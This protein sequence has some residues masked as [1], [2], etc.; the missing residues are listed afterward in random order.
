MLLAD[1]I[2]SQVQPEFRSAG[3]RKAKGMTVIIVHSGAGRIDARI[4]GPINRGIN[5]RTSCRF[6]R[7]RT[8]GFTLLEA[9]VALIIFGIIMVAMSNAMA[10]ALRAR[11]LA[12]QRQE[13]SATARAIFA[14]LGRDLMSAYGSNYDPNSVFMTGSGS[15]S[16]GSV[17]GATGAP[18]LTFASMVQRVITSDSNVDPSSSISPAGGAPLSLGSSSNGSNDPP[19]NT[20][21]LIRY[22]LDKQTGSLTRIVQAIP[23]LQLIQ[24]ASPASQNVVAMHI[25]DLQIQFWDPNQQTWRS[26]WD[27]E[28]QNLPAPDT[29]AQTMNFPASTTTSSTSSGSSSSSSSSTTANPTNP[30]STGSSD[31]GLPTAVQV[32]LKFQ[33]SDGSIATMTTVLPMAAPQVQDFPYTG[34]QN[35]DPN[36]T[37]NSQTNLN[38]TTG[39]P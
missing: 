25:V 35:Y 5:R 7:S 16:S 18:L 10:G 26:D 1:R 21:A 13:D 15:G 33:R 37:P 30:N 28:Q 22:D 9:L 4:D 2:A 14:T 12:E 8:S 39:N 17:G 27:F 19:Q 23:N 11:A 24:Q 32:T 3:G 36:S 6:A 38:T 31:V 29:A 20:V 34:G